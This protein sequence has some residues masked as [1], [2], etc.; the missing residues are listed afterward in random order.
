MED[1]IDD[2]EVGVRELGDHL[3][4]EVRPLVREVLLPDVAYRVT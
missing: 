1:S 4:E 2:E 3:I